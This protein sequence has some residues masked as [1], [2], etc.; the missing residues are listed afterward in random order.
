MNLSKYFDHTILKPDASKE[1][2][3][4]VCQEAR[5]HEFYSVCVNPYYVKLVSENLT[6]SEVKTTSVI[7]F[8]L[9]ASTN[10]IKA[11]ETRQAIEDGADE[12]DMVINIAALKNKDNAVV[13]EDIKTVV[14]ALG[15]DTR[16]KVII[17][18]CLLTEEE[19]RRACALSMEAGANFVKTSTGFSKHGA[20][21]EDVRL[22]KSVVGDKLEVKASGGIRTIEDAMAMIEAGATRLG[23]SASVKIIQNQEADSDY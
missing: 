3:L 9:G 8:P 13:L 14:G 2:V 22:M 7:G 20:T 17:E 23:A 1:E 4:K 10:K 19:K 5:E 21:V 6:G 11:A 16:L 18:T 15:T 12:I